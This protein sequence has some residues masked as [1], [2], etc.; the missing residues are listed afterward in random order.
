MLEGPRVDKLEDSS[1]LDETYG[2][3][4]EM[5]GQRSICGW[6]RA[7]RCGGIPSKHLSPCME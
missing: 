1:L 6:S 7:C 3:A 2:V 5:R 4:M